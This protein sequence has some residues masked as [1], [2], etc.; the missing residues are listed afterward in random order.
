MTTHPDAAESG[1]DTP[2]GE[3]NTAPCDLVAAIHEVARS[4]PD[5]GRTNLR[6]G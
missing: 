5:S 1:N 6:R 3:T 4:H 2:A